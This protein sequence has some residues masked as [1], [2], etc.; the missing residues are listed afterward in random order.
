MNTEDLQVNIALLDAR[1]V[2][3]NQQLTELNLNFRA[4]VE[5]LA[6]QLDELRK[7]RSLLL[8]QHTIGTAKFKAGEMAIYREVYRGMQF[9][10]VYIHYVFDV[11]PGTSTVRY[12]ISPVKKDGT[13]SVDYI[14]GEYGVRED[15]LLS[16]E[17]IAE[18]P[19]CN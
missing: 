18:V 12:R 19:S 9:T 6:E 14:G 3:L 8:H 10:K 13:P 11:I 2:A 7:A 15:T 16:L 4:N 17:A 1:I 5:V